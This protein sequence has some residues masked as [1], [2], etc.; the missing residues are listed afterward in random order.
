MKKLQAA[1]WEVDEVLKK[2]EVQRAEV[3]RK[4]GECNERIAQMAEKVQEVT[5]QKADAAVLECDLQK[6]SAEGNERERVKEYS[7]YSMVQSR[8]TLFHAS[9]TLRHPSSLLSSIRVLELSL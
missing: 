7:E 9:S 1:S 8:S 3:Q 2:A 6:Q 5:R 4:K